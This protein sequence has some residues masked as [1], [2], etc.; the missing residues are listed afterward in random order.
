MK[1]F[2]LRN[3]VADLDHPLVVEVVPVHEVVTSTLHELLDAGTDL[4]LWCRYRREVGVAVQDAIVDAISWRNQKVARVVLRQRSDRELEEGGVPWR[5]H[6]RPV[7][8]I[9]E[10]EHRVF[11]LTPILAE[12]R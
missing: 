5:E 3:E 12:Y 10:P 9:L 1:S 2:H 11:I 6:L 7:H 4:R 8:A